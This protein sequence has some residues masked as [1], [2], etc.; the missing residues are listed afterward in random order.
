[1]KYK[2]DFI[3]EIVDFYKAQLSFIRNIKLSKNVDNISHQ[4]ILSHGTY[5]PWL[6]DQSFIEAYDNI[7]AHTLVDIY[8]CYELWSL[9]K[10]QHGLTGDVL[11]VGVWKGGTGALLGII[12]NKINNNINIYL[13]DTFKG[14]VKASGNDSQYKGGEHSDTS[15]PLLEKLISKQKLKNVHVL[16]GIFPDEVNFGDNI[17]LL[18]LCHIDVDTYQSAKDIF[19]YIWP[20]IEAGGIVVFDDYGFWGCEGVTKLCNE[21]DVNDGTFIYNINGHGIFVKNMD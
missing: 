20:H 2:E 6:D 16:Q 14:V 17:P 11:E 15:L 3:Q 9:M 19:Y 8:R 1:M 5:A 21:I 12:A 4:H 7:K 13:A 18:R 10:Q